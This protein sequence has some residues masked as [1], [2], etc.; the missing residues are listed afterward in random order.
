MKK[1]LFCKNCSLYTLK[2]HCS[3]GEI[4][5]IPKPPKFGIEDPYA[6]YRRQAKESKLKE[7]GLI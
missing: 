6:N 7:A 1:M 2:S 5:V 4:A 3:C